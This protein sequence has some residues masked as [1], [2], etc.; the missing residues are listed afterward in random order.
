M[1]LSEHNFDIFNEDF[2]M[3]SDWERE[4]NMSFNACE[5]G[6]LINSNADN[7]NYP[8]LYLNGKTLQKGD[9]H[10]HIGIDIDSK[11][12]WTLLKIS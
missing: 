11:L 10:L 1:I 9:S 7:T 4:C 8:N 12:Q 6:Y 3:V 5:T 2:S